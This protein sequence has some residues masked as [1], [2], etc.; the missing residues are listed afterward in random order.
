M[1]RLH[2]AL[3]NAVSRPLWHDPDIM[4]KPMPS[5][6]SDERCELLIVGGG[7]TGLW[8]ALQLKERKQEADIVLIEQTYIGDGASGRC[9]GFIKAS[10]AHGEANTL[11]QFPDEYNRLIELGNINLQ[12]LI[13]TLDH[14]GIDARYEPVGATKVALDATSAQQLRDDYQQAINNGEKVEFFE[15]EKMH[16]E[17]NSPAFIA[18]LRYYRGNEGILDPARLCW[19]L[20]K[21]LLDYGVRIYE[22]T[23]LINFEP[24]GSRGMLARCPGASV[25]SEKILFATNAFP[26]DITGIRRSIVPVWDY[27]IA[28]EPLTQQQLDSIGWHRSRHALSE[29]TNMFHYFRMTLDNRITWGGGGAVRYYFNNGTDRSLGDAPARYD[30]LANEFFDIFPQLKDIN[31]S[32]KWGGIIAT[33][34]RFC[35][36]PGVMYGGR[37]AWSVGYTGLGVGASRFGARIAIELLGYEPSEIL[38]MKFVTGKVMPWAPEPFRWAGIRM[39]QNALIKADKNGG[40]RGPWLKLLDRLNLGFTC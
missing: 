34:T 31:F 38:G 19:G 14:Y 39:T 13:D 20:K 9:G 29:C 36:V 25:S 15:G 28:T 3:V 6:N 22:N 1:G 21:V 17:V 16:A 40:S 8:A 30:Q 4:P 27:Q 23:P 11:A 33:S 26:S 12:E 10:I 35:M 18:G 7:F 2:S 24:R 37:V 32:N 5:L